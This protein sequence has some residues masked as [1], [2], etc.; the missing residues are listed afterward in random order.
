MNTNSTL[1]I[2]DKV[3]ANITQRGFKKKA[4]AEQ[5]GISR[6]TFD[7]R[8][9]GNCFQDAEIIALKRLGII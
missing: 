5:I 1:R 7:T 6:Q 4:I 8:L 2:A 3:K 9:K